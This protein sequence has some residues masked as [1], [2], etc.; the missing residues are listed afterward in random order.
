MLRAMMPT[1]SATRKAA[2]RSVK[3]AQRTVTKAARAAT[4][5]TTG[6]PRKRKSTARPARSSASALPEL[7]QPPGGQQPDPASLG[8]GTWHQHRYTGVAGTLAYRVYI[9]RG[10]RRTTRAPLVLALHGCTQSGLDFA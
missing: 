8:K 6:A 3:K 4:K 2:T 9:P 5:S 7:W 1:P 10:L